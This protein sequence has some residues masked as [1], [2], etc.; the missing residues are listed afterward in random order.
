MKDRSL[1]IGRLPPEQLLRV[2]EL[3]D[4]FERA[5]QA[6]ERPEIEDYLVAHYAPEYR[7]LLEELIRLDVE[8][9]R[10]AGVSPRAAQYTNRF[11]GVDS[12]WIDGN[13]S[14]TPTAT[15]A[16]IREPNLEIGWQIGDRLLKH[17]EIRNIIQG[18]MGVVYVVHDLKNPDV[19]A[20][21][22]FR[23][24][25]FARNPTVASRFTQEALAWVNLGN[26]QNIVRAHFVMNIRDKPYLFLDYVPG[27]DLKSKIGTPDFTNDLPQILH[28]AIQ[29]CD[30]MIHAASKG[31]KAHRDIKPK[32]CFVTPDGILKVSDFGLAK[33]YEE[34]GL[35]SS[36]TPPVVMKNKQPGLLGRFW[37]L[38]PRAEKA[39][40]AE[41]N[42]TVVPDNLGVS[43]TQTGLAMG[44][45]THMAPEQFVDAKHVDARTDIYSFGVMLFQMIT[46]Q[47]P[48][49][50]RTWQEFKHLHTT[51]LPPPL[52]T[53]HSELNTI[54]E[55]CL[56][57]SPAQRFADFGGLRERLAVI[58]TELTA[59]SAPRPVTG[60][61]LDAYDWFNRGLTLHELERLG[62][63]LVCFER[64]LALQHKEAID[65]YDR[66]LSLNPYRADIWLS[67]GNR[68]AALATAIRYFDQARYFKPSFY[69][70]SWA[71]KAAILPAIAKGDTSVTWRND[72]INLISWLQVRT[73]K[74]QLM[75]A[76][77]H[78]AGEALACFERATEL[79]P[80]S[81]EAW[82]GKGLIYAVHFENLALGLECLKQAQRFGDPKATEAIEELQKCQ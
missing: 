28:F 55:R 40:P 73:R 46:G 26:H 15:S 75:N 20:V 56:S 18:G 53:P 6:D 42:E 63:A 79:D 43:V 2:D 19:Y 49:R 14:G 60:T 33:V 57:K 38:L 10:E 16:T 48:L 62:D 13:L 21:K 61:E 34:F 44:T 45:P 35:G 76:A 30:G 52:E 22:T 29:F 74:T 17:L 67:K 82:L 51:Q 7:V 78:R 9:W 8:Y 59:K 54:V 39:T 27:G 31:I 11:S 4:R 65:C 32:N 66:A 70:R 41:L 24:E 69:E 72:T 80:K 77:T 5:W 12:S 81:G 47:L 1:S 23:D 36:D 37:K 25:V 58:Y 3:C 64:A 50:G 71:R 68:L